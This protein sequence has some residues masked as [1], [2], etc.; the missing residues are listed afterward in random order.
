ML[1]VLYTATFLFCWSLTGSPL[2]GMLLAVVIDV[3]LVCVQKAN[4]LHF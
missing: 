2:F 1:F 4:P 3:A